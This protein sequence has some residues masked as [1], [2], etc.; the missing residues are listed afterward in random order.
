MGVRK[1]STIVLDD[2]PSLLI[3]SSCDPPWTIRYDVGHSLRDTVDERSS[4]MQ[5]AKATSCRVEL[6]KDLGER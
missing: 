3:L 1:V 6:G 5:K 4:G 2:Q